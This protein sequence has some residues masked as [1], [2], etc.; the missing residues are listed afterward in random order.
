MSN[1]DYQNPVGVMRASKEPGVAPFADI[2]PWLAPGTKLYASPREP[3][4]ECNAAVAA[5]AYALN[6]R[7]EDPLQFLQLWNEGEFDVLR[8]E[9]PDAPDEIYIGADPLFKPEEGQA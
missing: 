3:S 5:I 7:T 9:W 6:S 8:R 4:V 2:W 1:I